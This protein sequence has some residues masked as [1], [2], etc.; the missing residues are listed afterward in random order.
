M[1]L[2]TG[3]GRDGLKQPEVHVL[4]ELMEEAAAGAQQD[5]QLRAA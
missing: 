1:I 4:R 5:G 3:G 2:V